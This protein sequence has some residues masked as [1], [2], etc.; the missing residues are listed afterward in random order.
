MSYNINLNIKDRLCVIVGGGRAAA[1]KAPGL[2]EAGARVR[3]IAPNVLPELYNIGAEITLNTYSPECLV[4][5][6]LVFAFTD[7]EELNEIIISDAHKAGALVCGS[8]N[9]DFTVPSSACGSSMTVSV[10]TGY[11]KL[12]RR[13]TSELLKYDNICAVLK[14]YRAA[15]ISSATDK[16]NKDLLLTLAVSDEMLNLGLSDINTY[17]QKLFEL[18]K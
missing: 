8:N 2:I 3:I 18:L 4:N 6:F 10:S 7:N 11:P 17:K 16:S 12:S 13:L 5:A 1:I 9:G 15:V 14:D